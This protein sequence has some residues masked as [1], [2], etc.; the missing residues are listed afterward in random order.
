MAN[1]AQIVQSTT[2]NEGPFWPLTST[3]VKGTE[4]NAARMTRTSSRAR[5]ALPKLL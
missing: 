5:T 2:W 4:I 1:T 3:I